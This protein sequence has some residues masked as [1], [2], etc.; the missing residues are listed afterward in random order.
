MAVTI[1][2]PSQVKTYAN[3]AAFPA[4]GSLKTIYIA[5][6]TNKTYRWTGSVYVEISATAASTWGAISG[7][8]S[9]Q[10]DLQSALNAKE[11]TITSGT[12]SQYFR[13]DKTFQTLDKSAVGLSNVDNTSDANKPVSTATQT[14][15]N[16]KQNTLVS[17]TS[18][19]TINSTSL[20]GSGDVAVQPTLVSGT[21]IKT[22]EG[23][24]LLGSGNID[25]TKSDVGLANVDNTS[26]ANKPISTATQTALNAK[27][28]SIYVAR[29]FTQSVGSNSTGETQLLQITIPANSFSSTD[30]LSFYAMF[31]KTG[32]GLATTVRVKLSTS[33]SMP[34]G[35]TGCIAFFSSGATA[36]FIKLNRDMLV[37]G[38]NLKGFPFT[39][40]ATTD[41]ATSTVT[42]SSVAFDVT[43]TQY[44][45][46]SAQPSALSTDV[47]YLE[48]F[49][50]KDL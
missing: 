32:V 24:S 40:S 27:Q 16:A 6:D 33:S 41:Q 10:T 39:T 17:G 11:N 21:N 18:I 7:T 45:Y 12:T 37:S 46:V 1:N 20:L 23:Q 48:A 34:S 9:N 50:I 22:I 5:E 26:D 35:N 2:V 42:L 30:K 14:A 36:Q 13:G 3:L 25:L 28:N 43:Q 29:S 47:T 19:K 49:E 4:T 8:L 44:L 38:G 31:S 15:L